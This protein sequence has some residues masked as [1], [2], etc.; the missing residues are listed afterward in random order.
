VSER[1][2]QRPAAGARPDQDIVAEHELIRRAGFDLDYY[3]G[4]SD[5]DQRLVL[6]MAERLVDAARRT[7]PEA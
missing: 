4:L 2:D 1:D 3:L 5:H 7:E 6:K